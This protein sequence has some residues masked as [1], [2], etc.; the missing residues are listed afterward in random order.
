MQPSPPQHRPHSAAQRSAAQR[1][2]A[3]EMAQ[4]DAT[5]TPRHCGIHI[6]QPCRQG[7]SLRIS[8]GVACPELGSKLK[9]GRPETAAVLL[10]VS[11]AMSGCRGPDSFNGCHEET[12]DVH[13]WGLCFAFIPESMASPAQRRVP[14]SEI[15][16]FFCHCPP[17]VNSG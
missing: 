7:A 8:R 5:C 6:C 13:G 14:V 3:Q 12:T 16:T 9:V 1:S 11:P 15:Q 4:R 2:A 10:C 17:A